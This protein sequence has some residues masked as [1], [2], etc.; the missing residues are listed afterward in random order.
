MLFILFHTFCLSTYICIKGS[1]LYLFLHYKRRGAMVNIFGEATTS[2]GVSKGRPGKRGLPGK[3]GVQGKRGK[4]G[5]AANFYAQYFQHSKIK[6]DVDFEPNFWIDGYDVQTKSPFKVLNKYDHKYDAVMPST[7]H[8]EPTKGTDLVT[9][10]HTLN[11]NGT[12]CLSCP[13]N[14]N[15]V[16][17]VDNLQVFIVMRFSD[18]TGSYIDRDGVFGN[19]NGGY[20]RYAALHSNKLNVG[21]ATDGGGDSSAVTIDKFPK[22][23]NPIQTTKFCVLSFHWNNKGNEGCG[24]NKSSVFCN[25]Q[26]LTTFTAVDIEGETSFM[27]GSADFSLGYLNMKGEIGRFLV[28]GNR[29]VPMNEDEIRNVHA[30]LMEEWKINEKPGQKGPRGNPG[31]RGIRGFKG[32]PGDIGPK[33]SKG[34]PGTQG[35]PGLKGDPGVVGPAGNT[36]PQGPKGDPGTQ[37]VDIATKSFVEKTI[38]KYSTLTSEFETKL[39]ENIDITTTTELQILR[40]WVVTRTDGLTAHHYKGKFMINRPG[41]ITIEVVLKISKSVSV[42]WNATVDL[43]SETR[44]ISVDDTVLENKTEKEYT[45]G[46]Y[47]RTIRKDETLCLRVSCDQKAFIAKQGSFVEV[48]PI[49]HYQPPELITSGKIYPWDTTQY[50]LN[51]NQSPEDYNWVHVTGFKGAYTFISTMLSPPG[52]KKEVVSWDITLG[53][54]DQIRLFFSGKGHQ[55][56][57]IICKDGY[58]V[59]SIYGQR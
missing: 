14:W 5:E 4:T 39:K 42:P 30:Y 26:R 52:M 7:L 57:T 17:S 9:G 19:D 44:A 22:D 20:D 11:F 29:N 43:Y 59:K 37:G 21:G 35:L 6:W 3:D 24:K 32:D 13:M 38:Q 58:K 48:A 33:G 40:N 27:I 23:A 12:D 15:T 8:K 51:L 49:L 41:A 55:L 25:G 36:G 18:L 16:G 28:C 47:Y 34:D 10:R 31:R 46:L 54:D 1:N 45:V 50:K 56:L 53:G 2:S